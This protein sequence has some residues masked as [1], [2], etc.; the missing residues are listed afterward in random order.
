MRRLHQSVGVLSLAAFLAS[1]L[2]MRWLHANTTGL[3]E[4]TRML[5]RST[6]I[7]LLFTALLNLFLGLYLPE[8]P[9]G[10]RRWTRLVGS[11]LILV[12]PLLVAAGFLT[13]PWLTGLERPYS[14][15]GVYGSLAGLVL[16][17]VS[18]WRAS[19]S[20]PVPGERKGTADRKPSEEPAGV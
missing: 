4:T 5:L 13:A 8:A 2:Y 19:R 12:A 10:W 1:G 3:D 7:Y 18:R 15:W 17:A 9:A 11:V 16:H 20:R 6:H 14:R